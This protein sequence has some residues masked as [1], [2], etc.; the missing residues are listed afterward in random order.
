M[1]HIPG[2]FPKIGIFA[3]YNAD[4]KQITTIEVLKELIHFLLKRGHQL[5][6]E[7][8][9]SALLDNEGLQAVDYQNLSQNVD[10]IIVVGGD[11]SLLNAARQA[12]LH[13]VPILGINLGRLGF[14]ADIDPLN[15]QEKLIPI[16]DG[17]YVQEE[18]C[19]LNVQ[20]ERTNE[21]IFENHGLND[22]ALYTGGLARMIEF[23]VFINGHFVFKQRADGLITSTPSGSTA[24][25]LSA[26]GPILYPT[27]KSIL[28]VPMFAH[29]L[30]SRPI[31]VDNESHIELKLANCQS[32][33][34]KLSIDG[35]IHFE[36]LPDDKIIIKKYPEP[37]KLIHS[38]GH[39]HYDVLRQ[40]LGWSTDLS[41]DRTTKT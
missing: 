7:A 36:L 22:I 13:D 34:P 41:S 20:I 40:K 2:P 12:V 3:K 6:I 25:A 31:V 16:L 18:R 27:L 32:S 28:L 37:L 26:G 29:T 33:S 15:L 8:K 14:L 5:Q 24:Y 1:K 38:I 21:I 30:S 39:N 35:Q 19:L 11:G 17:L 10:L 23:E 9:T 4:P